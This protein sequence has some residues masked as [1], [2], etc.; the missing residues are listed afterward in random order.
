M[1]YAESEEAAAKTVREQWP[2]GGMGG[3]LTVDLPTPAHF[4][5]VSEVMAPE[6]MTEDIIL[7]PS[8]EKHID[9][10]RKYIDAGF[11]HVYVHQIGPDQSA[12]INFY[13]KRLLPTLS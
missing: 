9:G 10:I 4:E 7:G 11:D 3:S 2:N 5:A 1:C 8:L 12:F 13:T 6:R